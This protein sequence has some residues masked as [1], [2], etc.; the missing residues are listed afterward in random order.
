VKQ[1]LLKTDFADEAEI[2]TARESRVEL[3]A[4]LA[5]VPAHALNYKPNA[6]IDSSHTLPTWANFLRSELIN[7]VRQNS[8]NVRISLS[9]FLDN[10]APTHL[11]SEH[12][13]GE[14][15]SFFVFCRFRFA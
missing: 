13:S 10:T 12:N 15:H 11:N 6:V 14:P 9:G 1:V 5:S 2:L 4:A 7:P 3:R 8:P